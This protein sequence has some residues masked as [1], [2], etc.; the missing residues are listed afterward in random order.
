MIQVTAI[1]NGSELSYGE[2][3][4][5]QYAAEECMAGIDSMYTA[6]FDTVR[7]ID[8]MQVGNKNLPKYISMEQ[9]FYAPRQYF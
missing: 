5:F 1:F 2:G 9:V 7:F 6:D 3:D 8:L 4:S